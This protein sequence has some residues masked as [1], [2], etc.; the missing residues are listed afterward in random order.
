MLFVLILIRSGEKR[1][2]GPEKKLKIDGVFRFFCTGIFGRSKKISKKRLLQKGCPMRLFR[3]F[4]PCNDNRSAMLSLRAKRRP[5]G[6]WTFARGSI[7]KNVKITLVAPFVKILIGLWVDFVRL[8]TG[9]QG[10][11]VKN[12]NVQSS[13]RLRHTPKIPNPRV[14]R[15]AQLG[16]AHDF[17]SFAGGRRR[18]SMRPGPKRPK[19]K[20]GRI[21][22]PG[23]DGPQP[24]LITRSRMIRPGFRLFLTCIIHKLQL[25]R[26]ETQEAE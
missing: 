22:P 26:P 14:K 9:L 12:L 19:G 7:T 5:L 11:T 15:P 17:R 8:K 23:S 10:K 25:W 18:A 3:H 16:P 20:G 13:V 6:F 21:R 4:A 2:T 1:M 24:G